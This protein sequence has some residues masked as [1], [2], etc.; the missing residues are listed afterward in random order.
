MYCRMLTAINTNANT[1]QCCHKDCILLEG[2]LHLFTEG[3]TVYSSNDDSSYVPGKRESAYHG[4]AGTQPTTCDVVGQYNSSLSQCRWN[5]AHTCYR[6][7][8]YSSSFDVACSV[9]TCSRALHLSPLLQHWRAD[10][11]HFLTP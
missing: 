5:T 6:G 1:A 7:Q 11:C 10:I 4:A 9:K 3:Y 8:Y 2:S